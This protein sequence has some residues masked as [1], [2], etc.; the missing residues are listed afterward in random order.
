MMPAHIEKNWPLR[1]AIMNTLTNAVVAAIGV[2]TVFAANV[3]ASAAGYRVIDLGSPSEA[4]SFATGLNDLSQAVGTSFASDAAPPQPFLFDHGRTDLHNEIDQG[5]ANAINNQGQIV[6]YGPAVSSDGFETYLTFLFDHGSVTSIGTL[7]GISS[8]ALSINNRGQ[9]VG[10][11]TLTPPQLKTCEGGG[12]AIF[13][14]T[15]HAYLYEDGTMHDLHVMAGLNGIN[16]TANDINDAGQVVGTVDT[17]GF[18]YQP[19]AT[20]DLAV[21]GAKTTIPLALNDR[22][23][24]IGLSTDENNEAHAFLYDNGA[25]VNLGALGGTTSV[26]RDINKSG[27]IVGQATLAEVRQ[28]IPIESASLD[29]VRPQQTIVL[30]DATLGNPIYGFPI[31]HAFVYE[32]GIMTDLNT[33]IPSG[34]GWELEDAAAVNTLGQIVGTGRFNGTNRAF[35]LVSVPEP[36]GT[37]LMTTAALVLA[38][39]F[40]RA[41]SIADRA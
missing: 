21:A 37:S 9:I 33:L 19:G 3:S 10:N 13:D 15:V 38:I 11:S 22:G 25:W 17:H 34:S 41:R 20:V 2:F 40:L 16:S 8:G 30:G 31:W 23:Q 7:G 1:K 6:G 14:P 35:M 32:N 27:M 28:F 36:G 24:V 18:F 39:A 26:A 4:G 29:N 12:C 5:R